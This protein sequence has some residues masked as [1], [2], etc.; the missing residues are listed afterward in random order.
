MLPAFF[1][2]SIATS[3]EFCQHDGFVDSMCAGSP[4]PPAISP[5]I[6]IATPAIAIATPAIATPDYEIMGTRQGLTRSTQAPTLAWIGRTSRGPNATPGDGDCAV[7]AIQQ[8]RLYAEDLTQLDDDVLAESQRL[9]PTTRQSIYDAFHS[10][11][12]QGLRAL[13]P[14]HR[15]IQTLAHS[16]SQGRG[17]RVRRQRNRSDFQKVTD[18]YAKPYANGGIWLDE[19]A[20]RALAVTL[21]TNILVIPPCGA[22]YF[23]PKYLGIYHIVGTDHTYDSSEASV[24]CVDHNNLDFVPSIAFDDATIVICY[25]GTNHFWC[26]ELTSIKQPADWEQLQSACPIPVHDLALLG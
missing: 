26:T 6:A 9:C 22:I 18:L 17:S 8:S 14:D 19:P 13:L 4:L 21:G 11:D 5:A 15:C 20:L 7:V 2:L 1:A 12:L 10:D 25:N 16:A 24:Y 3:S 23:Y